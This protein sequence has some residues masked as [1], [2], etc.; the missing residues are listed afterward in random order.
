MISH[1]CRNLG[2]SSSGQNRRCYGK[3][4]TKN[5]LTKIG[6]SWLL[7]PINPNQDRPL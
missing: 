6:T 5:F 7:S 4:V 1:S 2:K 3:Q